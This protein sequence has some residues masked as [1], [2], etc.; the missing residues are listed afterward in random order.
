M[1]YWF[2]RHAWQNQQGGGS[3]T[4]VIEDAGGAIAGY[5]SLSAGHVE[6]E[7]LPNSIR[8]NQPDPVPVVLLGQLAVDLS[9]HGL[10]IGRSLMHF[11]FAASVRVSREVGCVGLVTFP[12]DEEVRGFYASFG[13]EDMDDDPQ[14]HMIVRIRDLTKNGFHENPVVQ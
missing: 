4:N 9:F 3:R 7:I 6:R 13:F 2:R 8:R 12:I 1:N 10:G 14:R 5:V 11:A